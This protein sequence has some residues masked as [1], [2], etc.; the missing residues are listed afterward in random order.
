MGRVRG[1]T[2]RALMLGL[3]LL[4]AG[5]AWAQESACSVTLTGAGFQY[6]R[7]KGEYVADL[8][9]VPK[10]ATIFRAE[11]MLKGRQ[12]F[13]RPTTKPTT[14]YAVGQPE[15][16]FKLVAPRYR[17]VDAL[18]AVRAAHKA[19]TQLRIKA[20]VT[21]SGI[22]SLELSYTGGTATADVPTVTDVK[23]TH[24][25]GQSLI[26][27]TEPKLEALPEFKTGGEVSAFKKKF[28]TEHK[29]MGFRIWRS[30]EPITPKTIDKATL[31]GRTGFFSCW[32]STY[33]QYRTGKAAPVRYRVADAGKPLPWGAGVY[34]HNPAKAGKAYYAV[35]VSVNGA[36]D[37]S[38]LTAANTFGP[39]DEVVGLGEP[40][41]QWIERI[42]KGKS[43]SYR[44][45]PLTRLIYVRWESWPH[46]STPNNPISY[47]VAM[48]ES[49]KP[50]RLPRD[51]G[52]TAW[53]VEPAPVGLQ[54]HCWGG[55]LNGGYGWWY[56]A[57]V[58]AILISSNQI[59]YDWWTGYHEH[60]GTCK[61]F[62]DGHVHPF[63]MNRVFGF[64]DWAATQW[65]DAPAV[66]RSSWRKLDLTRVFTAGSSMGGSGAPMYA[67]R[68]GDRIASCNGWVGVHIPNMSP[69]FSGSYRGN[70]GREAANTTMPDGKTKAWDYFNDVWW[71][72]NHIGK[73][74]GL[75]IA[76]NGKSDGAIGWPQA[77]LFARALQETRRPHVYN[78]GRG[79]HGT[80]TIFGSNIPFDVRTDQ[81][82]PAFTNCTLDGDI[83]TGKMKSKSEIQAER[84]KIAAELKKADKPVPKRIFV[85]PTDGSS[86]GAYNAYLRWG[87]ADI[88]DTEEAW[89][90]T[91]YLSANAPKDDCKVD[92]TPRRLQTFKTPKGRSFVYT[93]TDLKDN[94]VLAQGSVTA[95]QYDLVTL[96]QIPVGKAKVRVRIVPA[97]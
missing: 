44:K 72:K 37:F 70:Y 92:L 34:A 86:D 85:L 46:S 84:A 42:P 67:I 43:W 3:V 15:K 76:S 50:A 51:W 33:H 45:G 90:M 47:L 77:Y 23:V 39:V 36:E 12:R 49:P 54:L 9:S 29:G 80:R 73:D 35:T 4:I 55:S 69:Q 10:G 38:K 97:K 2:V 88:V 26:T 28:L 63:S 40:V 20:A 18:E 58:G 57:Q 71:M 64:L 66:C 17:S 61:T 5:A 68:Y 30:E 82:L 32:N 87:F 25:K 11:L 91:V 89:E 60:R 78:W 41:L 83:G 56:N 81:S 53:R 75:I 14:V 94:K 52:Q 48:G 27:F 62:G 22:R 65:Q 16:S 93:V 13:Q 8:L 24:R 96:K 31:V 59:P 7:K 19:G 21:L 79:G 6:D 95:D 1:W 74:T